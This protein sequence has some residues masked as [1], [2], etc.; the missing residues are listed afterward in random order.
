MRRILAILLSISIPAFC[1][2]QAQ[3]TTK[4]HKID[5]FTSKTTKVVISGDSFF[6]A[7][8][9][10]AVKSNWRVSP[11]EFCS[12]EEFDELK[13][14]G[15]YYFLLSTQGQFRKEDA[16]GIQMLSLVKGGT[17]NGKISDMLEIV[18]IPVTS[19]ENPD[20][21]ELIFLP[22]FLDI[23]QNYAEASMAR[24]WDAYIGLSNYNH[25]LKSIKGLEVMI[26]TEDIEK[27]V[28]EGGLLDRYSGK[29]HTGS[30]EETDTYMEGNAI[31][32]VVSYTVAPEDPKPGSH[33]YKMLIGTDDHKLYY[34]RKHKITARYGAG[35]LEEDIKRIASQL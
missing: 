13:N 3:I 19:L 25:N 34:F 14:S 10:D 1:F 23:I 33:C 24:D 16:P 8:L 17:G 21:R 31:G 11:Y 7:M 20:G 30:Y 27:K 32:K 6:E 22:A 9:E 15:D 2:A 4:K 26:A 18:S 29:L 28:K 35:F 5:D 12:Q